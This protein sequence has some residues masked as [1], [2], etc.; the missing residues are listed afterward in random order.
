MGENRSGRPRPCIPLATVP[1]YVA[2]FFDKSATWLRFAEGPLFAQLTA[3]E[4]RDLERMMVTRIGGE[5]VGPIAAA[6]AR[7]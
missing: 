3:R 6:G 2:P 1:G 7:L 5:A 4:Q